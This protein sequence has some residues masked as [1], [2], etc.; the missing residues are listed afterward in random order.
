MLLYYSSS[1]FSSL[2]SPIGLYF[3]IVY[4]KYLYK[5]IYVCSQQRNALRRRILFRIVSVQAEADFSNSSYGSLHSTYITIR[6]KIKVLMNFEQFIAFDSRYLNNNII[7]ERTIF[8]N[9][10][11]GTPILQR[12]YICDFLKNEQIRVWSRFINFRF[13]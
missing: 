11:K 12:E 6:S 4:P 9:F 1:S 2:S 13:R 7:V 5:Y 10:M 8:A 3:K